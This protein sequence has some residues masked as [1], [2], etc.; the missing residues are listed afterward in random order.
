M[1]RTARQVVLA[2]VAVLAIAVAA[3]TL[4]NPV[5]DGGTSGS[6][7]DTQPA[8][9][10]FIPDLGQ[11]QRAGLGGSGSFS[12][13]GLCFPVLLSPAFVIGAILTLIVFGLVV[14]RRRD[15]FSVVAAYGL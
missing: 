4:P 13:S 3:A 2:T 9:G 12:L 10:P 8:S 14:Y 15:V 5:T 7:V 1:D 11:D 6:G